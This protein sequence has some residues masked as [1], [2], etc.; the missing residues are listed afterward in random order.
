VPPYN[1]NTKVAIVMCANFWNKTA[2]EITMDFID[3]I[4]EKTRHPN[5]EIIIYE[6]NSDP[7]L[8]EK[9][10]SFI[11]KA[12]LNCKITM[13]IPFHKVWFSF[14]KFW[15][16]A[17]E[18]TDAEILV[19]TNNDMLVI[20]QGWLTN[21]LRWFNRKPKLGVL[22]PH[23][24][25]TYGGYFGCRY[26]P[27]KRYRIWY[28]CL[29]D[30]RCP[31]KYTPHERLWWR[32][33][34]ALGIMVC[35]RWKLEKLGGF[36]DKFDLHA[37]DMDYMLMF[38]A[39]GYKNAV[40]MDS[41]VFHYPHQTLDVIAGRDMTEYD[42]R[43][44]YAYY[45]ICR[46]W[47]S[48]MEKTHP[49]EYQERKRWLENFWKNPL[50][51]ANSPGFKKWLKKHQ[52]DHDWDRDV[53]YGKACVAVI[54]TLQQREHYDIA[55]NCIDSILKRTKYDN[56]ELLI[57][58][59][60]SRQEYRLRLLDYLMKF[61]GGNQKIILVSVMYPPFDL[62]R[63]YNAKEHPFNINRVY[64]QITR[65][66]NAEIFAFLNMDVEVINKE[67]LRNAV[68]W[69]RFSPHPI[70]VLVTRAHENVPARHKV[71]RKVPEKRLT[72]T[73]DTPIPVFFMKRWVIDKIGGFDEDFPFSYADAA[74]Y[75]QTTGI[76]YKWYIA[77]DVLFIHYEKRPKAE[78]T[79]KE[80]GYPLTPMYEEV[81]LKEK[82]GW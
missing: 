54:C 58:E 27:P 67:W 19:M 29:F 65:F 25:I 36:D 6:N 42:R 9:F 2:T 16:Q 48:F 73:D 51:I 7:E 79:A 49:G 11:D 64:N 32:E 28:S 46:K 40:A 71:V 33:W 8:L 76:E 37:Q 78:P 57:Y 24:N 14:N 72:K 60:L 39:G 69:L 31:K 81:D 13:I 12:S 45:N 55:I 23:T 44:T 17:L 3:S 59:N 77:E 35:E 62:S 30:E 61:K 41:L 5:Y 47:L 53:E 26:C 22:S 15:N 18:F 68:H 20:N 80:W 75:R 1:E 74:L 63:H 66:S 34:C 50:S 38:E 82:Y 70:G 10:Y 4:I 21:L 52:E 43:A 56:W